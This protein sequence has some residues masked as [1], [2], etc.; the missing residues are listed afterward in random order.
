MESNKCPNCGCDST[1]DCKVVI[2]KYDRDRG[3][4][5]PLL[6]ELQDVFGYL[7]SEAMEETGS[8]LNIS[9]S[10]VYGTATFYTL[11]SLEAKGKHIIRYC[12]STPCHIEGSK[13]IRKA[14]E[15]ALE[16]ATGETTCDGLFTLEKV[17]CIGLCGVAPAIMIDQD[18][19]GNLTPEMIPAILDKYRVEVTV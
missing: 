14:I 3:N 19:Y 6:H 7:S 11:F 13:A 2:Q 17:S 12:D 10:D 1:S 16:I 4:L 9:L 8:W 15:N 5:I 18:A